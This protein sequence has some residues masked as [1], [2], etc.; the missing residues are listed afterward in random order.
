MD[1]VVAMSD[2]LARLATLPGVYRGAGD[3]PESGPFRSRCEV[4]TAV[5]GRVVLIDYEAVGADG[6]QHVDHCMLAED[7]RARGELHVVSDE[8]PGIVRFTEAEPGVFV[9]FEPINAKIV[10]SLDAS[11]ALTYA[12]WWSRDEGPA[13][14]QSHTTMRRTA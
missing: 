9:A 6:V 1:T 11:G 3:G 13:R 12:W 5:D 8:L 2:L 7:E 4:R 14:P 10:I